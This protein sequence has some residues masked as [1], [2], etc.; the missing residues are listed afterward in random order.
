VDD[1]GSRAGI[2]KPGKVLDE[3]PRRNLGDCSEMTHPTSWIL[4]R[5][6]Q[7]SRQTQGKSL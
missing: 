6:G 4:L 7:R 1:G 5:G 3:P 2:K